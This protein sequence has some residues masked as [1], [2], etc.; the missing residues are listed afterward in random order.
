MM[1]AMAQ[2]R[3][4]ALKNA[5]ARLGM[6]LEEYCGKL[7]AGQKWCSKCKRWQLI[8]DF[9]IDRSRG[10][11][12][13]PSC[14][15]STNRAAREFYQPRPRPLTGRSFVPARDGDVKQ[16]RRRVNYFVEAGLLPTPNS[17]PCVDCGH[18]WEAD[19][20]RH[21]YDHHLG[22]EA[23]HH[24]DVEVVCA[25]CH[26]NRSRQRGEDQWGKRDANQDRMDCNGSS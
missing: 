5:A 6:S 10:D 20:V 17:L 11:G 14:R 1:G 2:T 23:T 3:E 12:L 21:E 15:D 22:Y 8:E 7:A 18:I 25:N 24:E 19:G 9:A 26:H 13:V 4:G 16:A